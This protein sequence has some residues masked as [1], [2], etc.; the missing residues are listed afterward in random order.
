MIHDAI[1]IESFHINNKRMNKSVLLFGHRFK[2]KM[3][4]GVGGAGFGEHLHE[5]VRVRLPA[6]RVGRY[7]YSEGIIR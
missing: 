1:I 6:M 3:V 5:R 4:F 2:M 7:K